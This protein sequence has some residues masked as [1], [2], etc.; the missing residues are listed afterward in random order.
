MMMMIMMMTNI[1]KD[2]DGDIDD[3]VHIR[4][5]HRDE[6]ACVHVIVPPH[7]TRD[8]R[9]TW[10]ITWKSS[11]LWWTLIGR[12]L[13][14]DRRA[15]PQLRLH[16]VQVRTRAYTAA[17]DR[18][19]HHVPDAVRKKLARLHDAV[20]QGDA[21]YNTSIAAVFTTSVHS[22]LDDEILPT[23]EQARALRQQHRQQQQQLRE[24]PVT[25]A[26]VDSVAADSLVQQ[27]LSVTISVTAEDDQ[28]SPP[29]PSAPRVSAAVAALHSLEG[30]EHRFS[31]LIEETVIVDGVPQVGAKIS[32]DGGMLLRDDADDSVGVRRSVSPS[33]FLFARP[34]SPAVVHAPVGVDAD[35]SLA[36]DT[37]LDASTVS[38]F[39]ALSPGRYA[40]SDA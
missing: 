6:C 39:G 23:P 18:C 34:L 33:A 10:C 17:A 38:T 15:R 8:C 30:P 9:Q 16:E 32:V 7:S 4:V 37:N 2:D 1:T 26:L 25:E 13:R 35:D 5:T 40:T 12:R 20:W 3:D 24:E 36:L 22:L 14:S 29:S 28:V 11:Q 21:L 19:S 27:L 31:R